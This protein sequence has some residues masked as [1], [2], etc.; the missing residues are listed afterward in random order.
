MTGYRSGAIVG[1]AAAI[2][3]LRDMRSTT[4][5]A[6]PDFVQQAAAAAWADDSHAAQRRKVFGAKRGLVIALLR[7]PERGA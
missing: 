3:A 2:A 7:V 6:S 1:Y 5:T 4:G